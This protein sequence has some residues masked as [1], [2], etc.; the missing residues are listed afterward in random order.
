MLR[1]YYLVL[2]TILMIGLQNIPSQ[3]DDLG[4]AKFAAQFQQSVLPFL[5]TH[6]LECHGA[7][8]PEALFDLSSYTSVGEIASAHQIWAIVLKRLTA[9]EMPPED[10]KVQP[11]AKQRQEIIDW[12][13]ALRKHEAARN[14]G[15]PGPVLARRLNNHE[16][17][18]TIRDLTGVDIRP[19]ATFPID[20]ANEAGFDNSG[21][22]L[23]MSPALLNKYLEA[24]RQVVEHMVLTPSGINFAPHP[25]VTDT[26]R[27]KY[28]VKRIIQFYEQQP[29]DLADYFLA[30]W[31]IQNQHTNRVD[32]QA[33][34]DI[35]TKQKISPKYLR[36]VWSLLHRQ[37][38]VG[39]IVE[40][41]KL[42]KALPESNEQAV[43]I[44]CEAMQDYVVELRQKL[45][46]KFDSLSGAGVH[47]GSQTLVL[48]KNK[49]YASNRMSFDHDLLTSNT[50]SLEIP[51][52]QSKLA[53]YQ[54][55]LEYFCKVFPD[56]FYISERGRDYLDNPNKYSEK[57]R[58]LSA[59]FHSMM[60]Y[61]RDD[62]PLYEL[63][64]NTSDQHQLDSLWQ[65]LDFIASAPTRQYS[66]FLWFERTDSTFIRDPDFD[67]ARPEDKSAANQTMIERLSKVY[68]AKIK[69]ELGNDLVIQAAKDYFHNINKQIRWVD[70]A[71][72]QAEPLHL[73]A[74]LEFS[75]RAFRRPLTE[76]E[77]QD[78][79]SFYLELRTTHKLSHE[80]AIQ[81]TI[82][83]ILM[84]PHFNY[85]LDLG[86][87]RTS[88]RP[89]TN[90]ELAS[91]LSYFLWSSL[92]D[93]ELLDLAASGKLIQP[94][95]LL[96]QTRRML[97]DPKVRGL[98]TEFGGNWLDIRQFQDHNSVDRER[99]PSFT[100][101]LRQ[102]MFEE[103]VR[104][105]V[106]AFQQDRPIQSL[107]NA[108]HTFV[109]RELAEHYGID[110]A[111]RTSTE[112]TRIDDASKYGRGGLLPMSVFLTKNSPGLRTSPVKRGYWVVRRL[113][114]EEIPPPPPEVPE[115][116]DDE[117]K[118]GD[119]SLR[120]ML[121]VH[122]QHQA[123]AG[124]HDRFDAI[125]L[126]F[127]QYGP[128]GEFRKLDLGGRP[129]DASADFPDGSQG[130]GL[131][132]LRQYLNESR[133]QEFQ[134][135]LYHKMLSY[136]LGRTLLP[137]DDELLEKINE[138]LQRQNG[139][140]GCII[141]TIITS[142]QFLNKRGNEA[143]Q[144][145]AINE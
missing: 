40:L 102:A 61:Y 8:D 23:S 143:H 86:A 37:N 99:F 145:S 93:Q 94:E 84:S 115:L 11:S 118:L 72:V 62:V 35:A 57:G 106:D 1:N 39:P 103:P 17:N 12:I 114:G 15:D 73:A 48:W 3:A 83:L 111:G 31:Q 136:G 5:K 7:D 14:S 126:V 29:T 122:R 41:Q 51:D 119:L 116:P 129:V 69:R 96:Q 117:S 46:P 28:C 110:H 120:E 92:P 67:F 128:V 135:N 59:G 107:L 76:V 105:L 109:N 36:T 53:F 121:A 130:E 108:K 70:Q 100:N 20:P 132:G 16:F 64:L 49:Q 88:K 101:E 80:E 25:V 30:C 54:V 90:Q 138:E 124:C 98:A 22:S 89:L 2:F 123:C 77:Q 131:A 141:E 125:G 137:S 85:R 87:S 66:S 78:I 142:P 56:A 19:T 74:V 79:Q 18:Y 58:L 52:N 27:D 127:E 95:V 24:S 43:Q 91:R 9:N 13:Q 44:G 47:K 65:E 33:F 140:I 104:F 10:S 82:V 50:T 97:Q 113:L 6:C 55:E 63:I 139:R 60:G 34:H 32:Q 42:W 144:R 4:H 45:K 21:E 26:D 81:D 38:S 68:V 133:L 71:R 134:E 112:W 75:Q